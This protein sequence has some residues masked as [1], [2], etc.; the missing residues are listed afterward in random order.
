MRLSPA[1]S[2]A[3][4]ARLF[5]TNACL[6]AAGAA[7]AQDISPSGTA[8]DPAADDSV[9]YVIAESIRG[10]VDVP[11]VP[12]LELDA[13][14]VAAY[15]TGSVEELLEALAPQIGSG[16]GRGGG[17]PVILV[18]G[19]RVA[20]FREMRSYPPEAIEK[21]EVF[22]EEVAQSYGY[23]PDQRVVNLVLKPDFASREIEVEHGWPSA[24]GYSMREAEATLLKIAGPRRLNIN[25]DYNRSGMLTEAERGIVQASA[26]VPDVA[27]D[28][29]P[30]EYRSLVGASDA[31][32]VTANWSTLLGSSELSLNG[33][34]EYEASQRLQ[35]LDT[36]TLTAPD[37]SSALRSL[38][39]DDPLTLN[40]RDLNL[41]AGASFNASPGDWQLT[42]TADA[43]RTSARR[44]IARRADMSALVNDA[45]AGLLEIDGPLSGLADAG[46]DRA[47]T[48]TTTLAAL[49]TGQTKPVLLPGG[50]VSLT[51]D[52]GFDWQRI[53]SL[54]T[55]GTGA[56]GSLQR[57]D[58]SAGIN[59]GLPLTSRRDDFGAF[60][61]DLTA[62]LS[63]G[64]NRLS[65]FGTLTDWSAGLTWEPFDPLQLS[66]SYIAR[67]AAPSLTQLG[68]AEI[69]TPNVQVF[70]FAS[71]ETVDVTVLTGGNPLLPAQSQR[72]WKFG[73]TIDLP[74]LQ[75]S[76]FSIEYFDNASRDVAA[77]FPLLTPAIEAAF[78]ER[79]SRDAGGMLVAIDRRPIALARQDARRLQFGLNLSGALGS[80]PPAGSA[81]GGAG[82]NT[83]A[84]QGAG[85]PN[86]DPERM[87]ALRE[88]LCV[89]PADGASAGQSAN[90]DEILAA[91][92]EPMRQRLTAPDGTIDPQRLALLRARVCS[93]D[94]PPVS[95]DRSA[96]GAQGGGPG[97]AGAFAPFG[98][99]GPGGGGGRWFVNLTY[100]YEISNKVLI[101]PGGSVLDQLGG[102]ALSGEVPRHSAS[103]RAGLFYNGF[104][105]RA[106][107][108]Y[109]GKSFI[110]GTGA[111]PGS[112]L[113]FD[114]YATFDLRIFADLNRREKL[115]ERLP[116]LKNTRLSFDVENIFNTRQTVT[117]GTGAVPLRYQPYL[118][119]PVGR[120]FEIEL[121]KTF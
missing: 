68:E 118:V 49:V 79:V 57:G 66:A 93:Q 64:L 95:A 71:G 105:A 73:A 23:S 20:S 83:V 102:E 86:F 7:H 60:M 103:L 27:G 111:N 91:M 9:I 45:A 97:S 119:D 62:S 112:D 53:A 94:V 16:R 74:Y 116:F 31:F 22:S 21:V 77:G 81:N 29:D 69:E 110:L 40:S 106:D 113:F 88:K 84:S 13:T 59:L 109:S 19:R 3:F 41:A 52:S 89:A 4:L 56:A 121:R 35:G 67:D 8:S 42:A 5:I 14:D 58:A 82:R 44:L 120:S 70:D 48:Q 115:I 15:G 63:A 85:R 65:D 1:T 72:D 96:G 108:S 6:I 75:R 28:P 104:G 2:R 18:N 46:E 10:S 50:E 11:Q 101:A 100:R 24:G 61:G 87:L 34:V 51:L 47:R 92:P 32:E 114:D 99:G 12:V 33:T 54:D 30:A 25:L 80:S 43:S 76:N 17:R 38:N 117:D 107:A 39:A 90:N 36:V 26:T 37:G 98:R 78:P 55:R